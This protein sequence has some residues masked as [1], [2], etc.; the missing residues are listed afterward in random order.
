MQADCLGH[1]SPVNKVKINIHQSHM[2]VLEPLHT[3]FVYKKCKK[4]RIQLDLKIKWRHN[5][6]YSSSNK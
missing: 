2:T 1:I 3:V 4:H 5:I 6:T